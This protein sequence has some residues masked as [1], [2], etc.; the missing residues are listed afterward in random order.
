MAI[1][2]YIHHVTVHVP[3]VASAMMAVIATY[4]LRTDSGDV[5]PLVRWLGW[6]T[7][8]A[9]TAAVVSGIVAAPGAFGGDGPKVLADHRNLGL[10]TYWAM[11][12]AVVAFEWGHRSGNRP[13]Q[14]FGAL[15]WW[16]VVFGA[17]GTGHWGGSSLH[18]DVVPWD[19][20][21]PAYE[22]THDASPDGIE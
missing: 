12:T 14:R 18:S 11:F 2:E 6:G 1:A 21:Q 15:V 13:T 4:W 3:L 7:L 8:L 20:T 10:T 22:R 5:K 9:T 19:G 16:A 17:I